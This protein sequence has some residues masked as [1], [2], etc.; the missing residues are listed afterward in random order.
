MKDLGDDRVR[1][2]LNW[3]QFVGH[4]RA[5]RTAKKMKEMD[6]QRKDMF[7]RLSRI[8]L[9]TLCVRPRPAG[10]FWTSTA[11]PSMCARARTPLMLVLKRFSLEASSGRGLKDHVPIS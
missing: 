3:I 5:K 10:A 6:A 4:L 1:E 9:S 2:D 8:R 11:R 7:D